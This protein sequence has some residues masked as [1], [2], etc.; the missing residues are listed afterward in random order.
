LKPEIA[1]VMALT[2]LDKLLDIRPDA[3][4]SLK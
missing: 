2:H 1:K 4:E 3:E